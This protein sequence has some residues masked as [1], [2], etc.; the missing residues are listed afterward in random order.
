MLFF[1]HRISTSWI[2][3][4]HVCAARAYTQG[5][6]ERQILASIAAVIG[7]FKVDRA[8]NTAA[9]V[10]IPSVF[11]LQE[12]NSVMQSIIAALYSAPNE[13][14][15]R[16]LNLILATMGLGK[17]RL[18]DEITKCLQ[19]KIKTGDSSVPVPITITMNTKEFGPLSSPTIK[20]ET[21]IIGRMF[22]SYFS[23]NPSADQ[24]RDIEK[25]VGDVKLSEAISTI[26]LDY[27]SLSPAAASRLLLF[28]DELGRVD[29]TYAEQIILAVSEQLDCNPCFSFVGTAL[30]WHP[31]TNSMV[32]KSG[33]DVKF[34]PAERLSADASMRLVKGTT[35]SSYSSAD[36]AFAAAALGGHPRLLQLFDTTFKSE[37]TGGAAPPIGELLEKTSSNI[38]KTYI[39]SPT[40]IGLV[41]RNPAVPG[42]QIVRD[43]RLR[44][45]I[46][47]GKVLATFGEPF[48]R[49]ITLSVPALVMRR[50][51]ESAVG[52]EDLDIKDISNIRQVMDVS[53][54]RSLQ[55]FAWRNM[56]GHDDI[57]QAKLVNS[58]EAGKLFERYH[59]YAEQAHWGLRHG[60]LGSVRN[61]YRFATWGSNS[62]PMADEQF[63]YKQPG[64]IV[65]LPARSKAWFPDPVFDMD[66]CNAFGTP[67]V[68]A[69]IDELCFTRSTV[70][71]QY[72]YQPA[73]DYMYGVRLMN[74]RNVVVV[75]DTTFAKANYLRDPNDLRARLQQKVRACR[76]LNW[77]SLGLTYKQNVIQVLICFSEFPSKEQWDWNKEMGDLNE[78]NLLILDKEACR[79]F[80]GGLQA[81][82]P[83]LY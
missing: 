29:R 42:S 53:G 78:P 34:F 55:R 52:G 8:T 68:R 65:S 32:T 26:L 59:M 37:T 20:A 47:S 35:G 7:P 77:N 63:T 5:D 70:V 22:M 46:A 43:D 28:A 21:T 80:Y 25:S 1:S 3:R 36:T 2:Y 76:S 19:E 81:F 12:R 30:E 83:F 56:S 14:D 82:T 69:A 60:K 73:F 6:R 38:R 71:P 50:S 62:M 64:R 9:K 40:E 72:R 39:L 79:L 13:K 61:F 57:G 33:R 10:C 75:V 51:L 31:V 24:L 27:N 67:T 45:A 54:W 17:S 41:L 58:R 49:P 18:V 16:D 15:K 66:L 48:D 23:P 44:E 4:V 11:Q 74:E